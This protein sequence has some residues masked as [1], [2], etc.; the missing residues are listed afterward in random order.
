MLIYMCSNVLIVRVDNY[1]GNY[2]KIIIELPHA[3]LH[4]VFEITASKIF[5][6]GFISI[7]PINIKKSSE[8]FCGCKTDGLAQKIVSG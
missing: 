8:Y 7:I 5:F 6:V 2:L 4:L 1:F 3:I